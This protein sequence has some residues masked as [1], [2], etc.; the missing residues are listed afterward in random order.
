[1]AD[2]L[3]I[4]TPPTRGTN[5]STVVTST[6]NPTIDIQQAEREDRLVR[7]HLD[8]V[9]AVVADVANRVPG[10]DRKSTRLNSS[11]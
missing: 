3:S 2:N 5:R 4:A 11:H 1:M 9:Q 7:Q 8:L 6:E 10:Q